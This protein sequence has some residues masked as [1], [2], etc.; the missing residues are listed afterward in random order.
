MVALVDDEVNGVASLWYV[1][2]RG[3][4]LAKPLLSWAI[5]AFFFRECR[6]YSGS[7]F[8]LQQFGYCD[9][10]VLDDKN[11]NQTHTFLHF[12]EFFATHA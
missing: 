3:E 8:A 12:P 9:V 4:E 11:A 6:R 5:L 1:L 7:P 2:A 10:F